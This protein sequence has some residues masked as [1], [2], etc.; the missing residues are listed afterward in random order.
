MTTP[1]PSA[2]PTSEDRPLSVAGVLEP[3]PLGRLGRGLVYGTGLFLLR[4]LAWLLHQLVGWRRTATVAWDGQTLAVH[5][6]LRLLGLRL[7]SEAESLAPSR[8]VS[9]AVTESAAPEP[10]VVGGLA[11]LVGLVWGVWR[12]AEGLYGHSTGL[13]LMGVGAIAIGAAVDL[14][15]FFG[16]RLFPGLVQ[17]GVAVRTTGGRWIGLRGVA[18]EQARRLAERVTTALR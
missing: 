4:P 14:A 12:I 6:E 5:S 2:N 15:I 7:R 17:A 3:Q 16:L 1:D 10:L 18:P 8:V 11:V 13:V 9:L